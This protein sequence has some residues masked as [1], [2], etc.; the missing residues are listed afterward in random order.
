MSD[1]R[2]AT[3]ARSAQRDAGAQPAPL[4]LAEAQRAV[5]ASILALGGY[6]PPLA[7]LARLFEE[8]GELAR[9]VNQTQGPKLVKMGETPRE[10][11][12]E[13]GDTLYTLLIL[14]NSLNIDAEQALREALDKVAH[15]IAPTTTTPEP[16]AETPRETDL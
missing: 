8:C 2:D 6:W 1:Q 4:T 3:D 7:N 9:V 13:L 16:P 10:A 14:A 15:R 12:E 5:D 11:R